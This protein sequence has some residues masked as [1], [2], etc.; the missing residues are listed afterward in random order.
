MFDLGIELDGRPDAL[1]GIGDALGR[2]GI[3]IEGGGMFTVDGRPITHFLVA[4]GAAARRVLAEAGICVTAVRK[5]VARRLNQEAPGQLGA[6]TRAVAEAG[7][8][9]EVLYSDHDHRLILLTSDQAT[10]DIAT[11]EWDR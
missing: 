3:S 5:V 11:K 7:A 6:I 10:A 4:D 8:R 1:A 9:I 2:A